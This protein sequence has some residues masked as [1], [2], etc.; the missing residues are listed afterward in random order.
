MPRHCKSTVAFVR[1]DQLLDSFSA[2]SAAVA[3]CGALG[4]DAS[5]NFDVDE[6]VKWRIENEYY[7][8][9]VYL[10]YFDKLCDSLSNVPAIVA[11][12][13]NTISVEECANILQVLQPFSSHPIAL[14]HGV[15]DSA[16]EGTGIPEDSE[17]EFGIEGWECIAKDG[18]AAALQLHTWPG[19]VL[20][21][22]ACA[23]GAADQDAEQRLAEIEKHL[24]GLADGDSIG[25]HYSNATLEK[26]LEDFLDFD[27]EFGE[28]VQAT[29]HSGA[30]P[31]TFNDTDAVPAGLDSQ[32]DAFTQL[33]M[34]VERV[35][36]MQN[37]HA[38]EE[39]AL[40]VLMSLDNIVP[41]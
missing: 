33:R 15:G 18:L 2:Q 27:D 32:M 38:K 22:S 5:E 4:I 20:K 30:Q 26:D 21:D 28:F 9:D 12:V 10:E 1:A 40:K 35:R 7:V 37:G 13:K 41:D 23:T 25:M 24:S 14:I 34:Q 36:S 16:S 29:P 39:A 8:A 19:L 11:L 31:H 3:L 6:P 17:A